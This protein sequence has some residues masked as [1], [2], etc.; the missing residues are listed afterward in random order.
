MTPLYYGDQKEY[1]GRREALLIANGVFSKTKLNL[2]NVKKAKIRI[3]VDGGLHHFDQLGITPTHFVGDQD[4]TRRALRI[5]YESV[6]EVFLAREK[7][8]TD[9][10]YALRLIDWDMIDHVT[11]LGALGDRTDHTLG[12][13]FLLSREPE[14]IFLESPTEWVFA[15]K[16]AKIK[17]TPGQKISLYPIAEPSVISS[18][19]LKWELAAFPLS[20]NQVSQSNEAVGSQVELSL[21]KGKVIAIIETI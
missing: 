16:R 8:E 18:K 10:E 19:G 6:P 9:L 15:V 17:T 2:D 12:N 14:K 20:A 13:M 3:A 11:I 1:D 7:D 5:K 21:Q 4:S